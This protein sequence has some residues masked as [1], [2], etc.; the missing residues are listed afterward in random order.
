MADD[1]VNSPRKSDLA[2]SSVLIAG[3]GYLGL[4]LARQLMANGVQV[5]GLT[6]S[7]ESAT[8]IE[9]RMGFPVRA[10]DLG[11]AATI[12]NAIAESGFSPG[13]V[14][15][16]ASSGRGGVEAY[17]HVFLFGA[18][19]LAGLF[20][21]SRL[22]FTSSTSVYAQSAGEEVSEES[23]AKPERETGQ[24]LREAEETVLAANGAVAR[25]A[26][27][28]GPGRSV[29]LNKYLAGEAVIEDGGHR[30]LNQIHR[31]DAATAI[32]H[33]LRAA[34]GIYN[35]SDGHPITQRDCYQQLAQ[36]LER[37]LPPEGSADPD[38]KRGV[39]NKRVSSKKLQ[40]TGWAPK[41]PNFIYSIIHD[42]RILEAATG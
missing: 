20:P 14:V 2:S 39:T 16:C 12:K 21:G 17:R 23:S 30:Y 35:V 26:G 22:I 11:D 38:R 33:L 8:N 5:M 19:N 15:H 32:D 41:Y 1:G 4:E 7:A 37:P 34:P 29:I 28:Y 27:I 24:I 40:H 18:R 25:L 9:N 13:T 10:A 6:H 3:C 42:T 31:D 36:L